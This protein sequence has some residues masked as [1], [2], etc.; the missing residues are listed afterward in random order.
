MNRYTSLL[1]MIS[2][3]APNMGVVASSS[4]RLPSGNVNVE[5][6][7]LENVL[8]TNEMYIRGERCGVRVVQH[9]DCLSQY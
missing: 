9:V 5:G 7:N 6:S 8:A 2:G 1:E 3:N 4:S